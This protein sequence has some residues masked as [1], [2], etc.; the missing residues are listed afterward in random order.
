LRY[1]NSIDSPSFKEPDKEGPEFSVI[2]TSAVKALEPPKS[3]TTTEFAADENV[4]IN[5]KII[6]IKPANPETIRP[7][8]VTTR[9]LDNLRL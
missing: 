6:T 3:K 5:I 7:V 4:T 8:T 1:P 9:L 2:V